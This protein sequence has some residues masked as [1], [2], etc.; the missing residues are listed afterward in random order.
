MALSKR[1]VWGLLARLRTEGRRLR[2]GQTPAPTPSVS[3]GGVI[4][5]A[6][7]GTDMDV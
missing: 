2:A 1:H 3:L 6:L 4:P 5:P 7:I